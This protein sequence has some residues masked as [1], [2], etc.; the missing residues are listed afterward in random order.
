MSFFA[1]PICWWIVSF[2]CLSFRAVAAASLLDGSNFAASS[3]SLI[4]PS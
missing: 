3:A 2:S 4:A 1:L